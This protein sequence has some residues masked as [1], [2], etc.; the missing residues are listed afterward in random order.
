MAKVQT[1]FSPLKNGWQFV[2]YFQAHIPVSYQ[3][4]LVGT[5][6]LNNVVFGL[7]GGM[8]AG[9][10]DFY[11]AQAALP[12]YNRPDA[13]D[14]RLLTF[15]VQRQVQSLPVTIVLR[16]VDWMMQEDAELA[17]RMT[18][19]EIPKLRRS[20][21][22]GNPA[23][24]CL[25][26]VHGMNSPAEN[27]QVVAE[28]YDLSPDGQSIIISLYDPNHPAEEPT[29]TAGLTKTGF[30]IA[31][32]SGE[33]LRGF[34]VLPYTRSTVLPQPA[35]AAQPAAFD[36]TAAA[37]FG[38]RWPVDSR[39]CT[40]RFGEHPENYA[41]FG[42]PGH[43]GL[44]LLAMDS[45][46]VYAAAD[47]DVF[48]ADS[49]PNHPYGTQIRIRHMDG[50]QEYQTVYAHLKQV[51]VSSGQHVTAGQKIALADSTGNS[52]GSHLHLTLKKIGAQTGKYPPGVVDPWPYLQGAVT[53]PNTPPPSPSGI[54]VYTNA[55]VN[56][57]AAADPNADILSTLPVAEGLAVLGD[58]NTEK[59]KIGQQGQWLQ[60]RTAS[61]QVGFVAAW[62]V[63]DTKTDP[64]PPSGII[65]YPIDQVNLR[66][67]PA[68]TFALIGSFSYTDPL[69]V[70]GDPNL[71]LSKIG[72][73]N[74]WLQVQ[75]QGGQRGFIAA[76]LVHQTGQVPPSA[77]LTV[78]P[79]GMVN[80]R[81][82]PSTDAN[83]LAVAM[84]GDALS[85]LGDRGQALAMIGQQGQWLSVQTAT[86]LNGYAA[87]WLV[88]AAPPSTPPP[89]ASGLTVYPTA[90]V[91][92]RAQASVNSPRVTGANQNDPLTVIDADLNSARAKVGQ[93]EQWLYV[94]ASDGT[95][96]W[97]A[98]WYL[99][100]ST[101]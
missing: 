29:I 90:G 70:L 81:A 86:R 60:V 89:S 1:T 30:Q 20:L 101:S 9:A 80:V 78:Y 25:I 84:A 82:R 23:V 8:S 18:R 96:G 63:L 93:Q 94:E 34:F 76:W 57:R 37:G 36:V 44:D 85:V 5:V 12:T 71:A 92:I 56:L 99:S 49:R 67:G 4:P 65:V 31:E 16:I 6:D 14:S 11:Y 42:L 46:S 10:L 2:N 58:A 97:A 77:G 27:H 17:S 83:I 95:R 52:S 88:Q 73:Q 68:T 91:N 74:Q 21:E 41:G 55:Q 22:G 28:G 38:L 19:L 87:A 66:E 72:Q 48:E 98:A 7:C 47:G 13:I 45:A 24:L 53:P 50:S 33:P 51:L 100:L 54:T 32:S 40:Q 15:L 69:S 62:L 59:A 35:P 64:L 3:L 61:G 75:A 43:E 39:V 79:L 26:R